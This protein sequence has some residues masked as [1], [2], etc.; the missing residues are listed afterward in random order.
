MATATIQ[1]A[2]EAETSSLKATV[3]EIKQINDK[4]VQGA[5]DSA[6]KVK[7]QCDAMAKASKRHS[8]ADRLRSHSTIKQKQSISSREAA[9]A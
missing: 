4:V 1:V 7:T 6:K 8:A 3:N 2:D 9:R 5:T